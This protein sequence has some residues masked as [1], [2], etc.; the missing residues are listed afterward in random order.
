MSM[1][2]YAPHADG[3]PSPT[4]IGAAGAEGDSSSSDKEI[5]G[6]ESRS[7]LEETVSG[8]FD[9]KETIRAYVDNVSTDRKKFN[10]LWYFQNEFMHTYDYNHVISIGNIEFSLP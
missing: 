10:M 8:S 3:S 2:P 6:D 9:M 5:E 7:D 1:S 4:N